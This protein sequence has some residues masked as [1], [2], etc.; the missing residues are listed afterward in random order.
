M[1]VVLIWYHNDHRWSVTTNHQSPQSIKTALVKNT[2]KIN[3]SAALWTFMQWIFPKKFLWK[4]P[5]NIWSEI[6]AVSKWR[7]FKL[8]LTF[9]CELVPI[10][11]QASFFQKYCRTKEKELL[12]SKNKAEV[13]LLSHT[14]YKLEFLFSK[15][16]Q[17][18]Y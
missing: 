4:W 3:I 10:S 16:W 9:T 7:S 14:N 6:K 13:P 15:N 5:I 18:W 8:C 12:F 2:E 17:F 1:L 11:W